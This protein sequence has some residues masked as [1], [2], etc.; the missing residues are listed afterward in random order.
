MGGVA[1]CPI[2]VTGDRRSLISPARTARSG[3]DQRDPGVDIVRRLFR[4]RR[5]ADGPICRTPAATSI[6]I[7]AREGLIVWRSIRRPVAHRLAPGHVLLNVCSVL[8]RSHPDRLRRPIMPSATSVR[9]R[10]W[11]PAARERCWS[12]ESAASVPTPTATRQR[13]FVRHAQQ[14]LDS[15]EMIES[16]IPIHMVEY[17]SRGDGR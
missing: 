5:P 11:K 2:S 4:H 15:D 13:A 3:T 17:A 8:L 1:P 12:I 14:R 9:S 7:V 6:E 10:P 16:S